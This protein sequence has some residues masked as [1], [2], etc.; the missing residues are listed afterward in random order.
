[1]HYAVILEALQVSD[2]LAGHPQRRGRPLF[3]IG[4]LAVRIADQRLEGKQQM[5]IDDDPVSGV[6]DAHRV[7]LKTQIFG[8]RDKGARSRSGL[9]RG[10]RNPSNR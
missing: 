6:A 10:R 2:D 1:M 8:G 5:E 9:L 7:I 3:Q 4:R